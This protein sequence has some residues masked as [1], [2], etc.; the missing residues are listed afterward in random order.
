[1]IR[2]AQKKA[3]TKFEVRK[4]IDMGNEKGFITYD[5]VNQILSP[6]VLSAEQVD[7]MMMLFIE[8]GIEVLDKAS[9]YKPKPKEE[10]KGPLKKPTKKRSTLSPDFKGNDPVRMYLH[11]MG[12]IALLTQEGEV[13]IAKRIEKGDKTILTVVLTTNAGVKELLSLG[14]RVRRLKVKL[15]DV[16]QAPNPEYLPKNENGEA[17]EPSHEERFAWFSDQIDLV[18]NFKVKN[19]ELQEELITKP[20]LSF[21]ERKKIREKIKTNRYEMFALVKKIPLTKKHTSKMVAK[22]KS[23][24]DRVDESEKTLRKLERCHHLSYFEIRDAAK[25]IRGGS[26]SFKRSK[27]RFLSQLS[28]EEVM[29]IWNEMGR[30]RRCIRAVEIEAGQKVDSLRITLQAVLSGEKMAN[31]AKSE[32]VEANLRL[33]VSI[34][35]RYLNRGLLFL[36]LIQEGNIGLMKAVDKF[37]YQR[38]FKFSTY[39]TWWIRQAITRSIA[40]QARTIR[41]PVHMIET[42]NKLKRIERSFIQELG[43]PA[44]DEELAEKLDLPVEKIPKIRKIIKEPVSLDTPIGDEQDSSLGDLIA[45]ADAINPSVAVQNINLEKQTREI[46]STLTPREEKVIRMRFGIGNKSDHTLEEVG[47]DFNVTRERI[48]QIEAKALQKLRHPSRS[49]NLESFVDL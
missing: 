28:N 48:R 15:S 46:L 6:G 19:Q 49:K 44:T 1:M 45:D 25:Q 18:Q 22:F 21:R 30:T 2:N 26:K 5:E 43:R 11:R 13:E 36:D 12:Q 29:E 37:E 42:I 32:L 20:G 31:K 35:K 41:I 4:L 14:E 23:L 8:L 38:G 3:R 39:A 16:L 7:D 33:V 47:R 17:I 24:L 27:N 10:P 34:A 9:Q 40:D